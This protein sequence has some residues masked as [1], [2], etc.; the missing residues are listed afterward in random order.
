V[1]RRWWVPVLGMLGACAGS[2][3]DDET[4]AP[5]G[6][7]VDSMVNSF[8]PEG[9]GATDPARVIYMGDSITAGYGVADR[10]AYPNLLLENSS[11]LWPDFDEAD[12][13]S[14]YPDSTVQKVD[15][16]VPGAKTDDLVSDQ[17]PALARQLGASVAGE[18]VAVVTIGGND[19]SNSIIAISAN[20]DMADEVI[21][22]IVDNL[23]AMIDFFQDE[24]RFP[25]GVSVY[26]ANVYEP[27]DGMGQAPECFA[28]VDLEDLMEDFERA[29]EAMRQ[30]GVERG[31]SVIDLRGHFL[32]HG[33]NRN[34]TENAGYDEADHELWFQSDC[35]HPNSTGH[36][37]LR[38]LFA[39]AI[40]GEPFYLPE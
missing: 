19:L 4:D 32:G 36:H 9:F 8:I 29:N 5:T 10:A 26:Y 12:L 1:G 28:G 15:V 14:I 22:N 7:P 27:T 6:P 40:R 38:R 35:I 24:T 21:E 13:G 23:H 17:L 33:Y 3:G 39:Q 37:E 30:V 34:D 16:S 2:A 18:S 20:P 31:A 11:N 25:D